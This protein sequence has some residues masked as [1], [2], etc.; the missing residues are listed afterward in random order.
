MKIKEVSERLGISSRAIRFYEENGLIVPIKQENNYRVYTEKDIWRLQTIISLREVGMGI[1]EI[2]NVLQQI[3]KGDDN[4]LRHYLELQRAAVFSQWLELKQI[5]ETTDR[6]IELLKQSQSLVLD[7]VFRLAEGSKR[8]R[9]LRKNWYDRWNFDCQASMYDDLVKEDYDQA[10]DLTVEWISPEAGEQGLDIGI[11]TG[12]LAGK[13]QERG[14]KMAG[15]DQSREMLKQC[16]RKYP[17]IPT[18]IGN[19]LAI[20]YM[21]GT[22]D[23]IVTSFA[24]HHLTDEQKPLALEEMRRVLK[25]HGRICITDLMFA[26]M[27]KRTDFLR[28]L[29]NEKKAAEIRQIEDKYYSDRSQLLCWF[30][31][32]GYITKHMQINDL[33]HI[34]LA[35]PIRKT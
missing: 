31:A 35:V 23:F 6:M 20:P 4:E 34:V 18:K 14:I 13:F 24:F 27:Q 25:P 26:D 33:L 11:G 3:D 1:K 30:D 2:R 19:F 7:D 17:A 22:F 16:Q 12:N 5:I 28:K 29:E 10:L 21:D 8:L 15:L 9:E 32:H